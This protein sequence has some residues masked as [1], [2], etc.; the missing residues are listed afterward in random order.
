MIEIN[1]KGRGSEISASFVCQM[2]NIG[3]Q[4]PGIF[5]LVGGKKEEAA[6]SVGLDVTD[7][8]GFHFY[9]QSGKGLIH[10]KKI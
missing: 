7:H 8:L 4:K 3:I 5:L 10:E 6:V 2:E 9:V 1:K